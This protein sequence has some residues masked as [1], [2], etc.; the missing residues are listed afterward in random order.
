[1]KIG[2]FFLFL[3]EAL[4]FLEVCRMTVAP[5]LRPEVGELGSQRESQISAVRNTV[6]VCTWRKLDE[7]FSAYIGHRS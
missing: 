5:C 2:A 7:G 6:D 4:M 1:M 3:Q